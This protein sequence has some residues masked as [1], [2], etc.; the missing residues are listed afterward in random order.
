MNTTI[1]SLK[2]VEAKGLRALTVGG[3]LLASLGVCAAEE[4]KQQQG[5]TEKP[6][7]KE[8]VVGKL[9]TTTISKPL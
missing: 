7:K 9:D 2:D 5:T 8:A 3:F 4:A 6:V 1:A